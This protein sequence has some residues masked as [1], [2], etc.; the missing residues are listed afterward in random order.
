MNDL[1]LDVLKEICS[2]AEKANKPFE[3]PSLS[4]RTPDELLAEIRSEAEIAANVN[5]LLEILI[6]RYGVKIPES[7]SYSDAT[8]FGNILVPSDINTPQQQNQEI[9]FLFR[10][11]KY[12]SNSGKV[13]FNVNNTETSRLVTFLSQKRL[14]LPEED[15]ANT[16][17]FI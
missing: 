11:K 14:V 8:K 4:E 15:S 3:V 1:I 13:N 5:D 17:D 9:P 6:F 16:I 7:S 2:L 12:V 10:L